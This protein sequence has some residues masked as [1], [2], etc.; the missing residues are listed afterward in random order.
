MSIQMRGTLAALLATIIWSGNFIVSRGLAA[1]VPPVTLNTVRWCI[2]CAGL[3]PLTARSAWAWRGHVREHFFYYIMVSIIG[4]SFYNVLVYLAGHYTEALNMSL[5]SSTSPLFVL[6]YCRVFLKER[7]SARRMAGIGVTLIGVVYLSVRG[8]LAHLAALRFQFGDILILFSASLFGAYTFILRFRPAGPGSLDFLAIIISMGTI[9][10]LPCSALELTLQGWP[11]F[12]SGNMAALLYVGLG[13]ALAA[14]I[15][16][17]EAVSSLGPAKSAMIYYTL[18][19]FCAVG[20]MLFLGEGI[21][22]VHVLGGGLIL[23][24]IIVTNRS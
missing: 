4:I 7:V 11:H 23:G 9:I 14:Y 1:D 3:L 21:S 15:L 20:A 22:L 5:I 6:L 10:L 18:P 24:G 19:F 2:A 8:D 13:P 16:W 12:T 17:N